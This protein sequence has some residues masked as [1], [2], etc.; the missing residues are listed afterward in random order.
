MVKEDAVYA[1]TID[2]PLKDD[3]KVAFKKFELELTSNIYFAW[4][5]YQVLLKAGQLF[6]D[7]LNKKL[8][9]KTKIDEIYKVFKKIA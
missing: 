2:K 5:K 9:K 1:I 4:K 7:E 3:N 8:K 6:L